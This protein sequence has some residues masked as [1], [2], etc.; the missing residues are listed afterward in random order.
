MPVN[1]QLTSGVRA[2]GLIAYHASILYCLTESLLLY[3]VSSKPPQVGEEF[4][5]PLHQCGLREG[6]SSLGTGLPAPACFQTR[7]LL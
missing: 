2:E 7:T 3:M 6:D 5:F 4:H 1:L